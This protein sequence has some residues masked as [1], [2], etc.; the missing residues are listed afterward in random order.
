MSAQQIKQQARERIGRRLDDA[1]AGEAL[2]RFGLRTYRKVVNLGRSV[3]SDGTE[4]LHQIGIGDPVTVLVGDQR[5]R[6]SDTNLRGLLERSINTTAVHVVVCGGLDQE[7]TLAAV[8]A[9]WWRHGSRVLLGPGGVSTW[10]DAIAGVDPRT[11]VVVLRA[12]DLPEPDLTFRVADAFWEAPG[13]RL[14]HWDEVAGGSLV[15]R[16]CWSP[17]MLLSANYLGRSFSLRAGAWPSDFDP[18]RADSWWAAATAQELVPA[19]VRRIPEILNSLP[20]ALDPAPRAG[21]EV[22]QGVLDRR[23]WPATAAASQGSVE[24]TWDLP[25]WPTVTIVV[26]SRFNTALLDGCLGSLRRTDY[27]S[28]DVVVIDNSGVDEHKEAW[29]AAQADGLD[30]SVQWWTEAPFNYSRVNNHAAATSD[31]DVIVFLNDDTVA[32]DP[33]WL[34]EMVG[35]V[36]RPEIGTV[37]LQLLTG[38]G[39]IQHGGVVL[40][41]DGFAGHL[42]GGMVPRQHTMIG[43]T[44]WTR[45]TLAVT[46][47]C[48]AVERSFW[49]QIGG[50]DERFVLCGSDVVLGLEAHGR[51]L[52]NVCSAR[53]TVQHLESATRE[54]YNVA[55]D[56]YASWWR[57]QRWLSGGDPFFSPLLE[58]AT[59]VPKIASRDT[60][61]PL[62]R[63]GPALGRTFSVFRQSMS[64][65]EG[66]LYADRC[67][68]GD[69][70]VAA[71][72]AAHAD[73]VGPLPVT[74]V[75]WVLPEF[76]NPFYGGINTILRLAQHL[77]VHHAVESR[78]VIIGQTNEAWYRSAIAA[79]FPLLADAPLLF[80]EGSDPASLAAVPPAD[81]AVATIW[82]SAYTVAQLAGQ[83]RKFY[84]VQDF[85]PC[86]YPAG[87]MYALAEETYRF[88]LYGICN[89]EP[90]FEMLEGRY[91]GVGGWFLPAVE[92]TVFHADRPARPDD[93]PIRIFLYA[94]LGHWRNCW[95][96]ASLALRDIKEA[97]GDRVHIVTAGSWA[98]AEDLGQGI[99]HLGLLEYEATAELYR[100]CDIGIALTVSEHP[101]YL[102]VE[103]MACG[104][105]VVAFDLP[106]GG[107]VLH[108]EENALVARRTV[109]GLREQIDRLVRDDDL[110]SR[111][112]KGAVDHIAAHHASWET[113]FAGVY[114]FLVDPEGRRGATTPV[115]DVTVHEQAP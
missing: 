73:A 51:G 21:A 44:D 18:R 19:Q 103:L 74:T 78:F 97:Y 54:G 37:G 63:V 101:S 45:N 43:H 24:V 92:P 26:P 57:Y 77:A 55:E 71:V 82:H 66:F 40:G 52:R 88:G 65:V 109:E 104:V 100:R 39:T 59:G 58:L 68:I 8:D 13:L 86:F 25:Q 115:V 84:M 16:P 12:G 91:G 107:W 99:E 93:D 62:V 29:Y 89:T 28:F 113:A 46:A 60:P 70:G 79:A 33:G 102:P 76:D 69:E 14:V 4:V 34:K 67:R 3:R 48:V 1:P 94:R 7:R 75:N 27:P 90:M 64:D 112:S 31:S 20:A 105:P 35:W 22:V 114:D 98:R 5:R 85:E 56:M 23:G 15:A 80:V 41:I 72:H 83:R 53:T 95:E 10:A 30:L 32:T 96:I 81:V 61:S 6:K 87:T 42:F 108:H 36:T 11:P 49:Q 111:L 17:D 2:A 110:R 9:Q 50:F 106:E 47:A 38:D